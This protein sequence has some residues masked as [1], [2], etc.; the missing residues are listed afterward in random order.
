V[1][2]IGVR[3]VREAE[4]LAGRGGAAILNTGSETNRRCAMRMMLAVL[5]GLFCLAARL[6][7]AD[8]ELDKFQGTWTFV[9]QE[10]N[11][12]AVPAADLK[13]MTITFKDD[14][15]T[16]KKGDQVVQAGTQKLDAA[17][18]PHT[19]DAMVTEG[20]GKGTTMLGIYE[21]SGNTVK[22]CFDPAGKMRPTSLKGGPGLMCGELKKAK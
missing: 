2:G 6:E 4:A 7:A 22:F 15:F 1:G 14:K 16:V 11:G 9:A 8:K 17:K 5:V 18:T 21:A 19:I 3:L 10:E 12:K 13:D 20:E